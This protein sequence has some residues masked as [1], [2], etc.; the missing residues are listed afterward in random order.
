MGLSTARVKLSNPRLP[1]L[2]AVEVDALADTGAVHL[3][4]PERVATQLKLEAQEQREVTIADGSRHLVDYVGPVEVSFANRRCFTGA[5][6]LGD[7]ILLGAIPMEDMDLV[8]VPG[9]RQIS[10]NPL[11]PNI[12]GSLAMAAP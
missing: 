11:R 12:P 1:E 7:Q 6:V 4:I 10:V 8:I 5:M 3:C 9:T 2:A